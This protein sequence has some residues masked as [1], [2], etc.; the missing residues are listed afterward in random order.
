ME[1]PASLLCGCVRGGL[2]EGSPGFWV[3]TWHHFQ[4]LHPLP[5][6]NWRPSSCFPGVSQSGWVCICLKTVWALSVN[7]PENP[8][9]SSA[10]PT[11]TGFYSQ[12][13]W[14]FIFPALEP[15][16]VRSGLGLGS[17]APKVSLLIFIHHTSM[18]DHPCQF[19]HC[20]HCCCCLSSPHYV[21]MSPPFPPVWMNGLLYIL[22]CQTSI[23]LDFF[24]VLGIICFEV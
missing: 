13:L 15:W 1:Q 4:S 18:W 21:S 17:L 22:G 5:V 19:C 10:A 11:P 8:E 14:G 2:K 3:F 16:T 6:C 24:M 20:H 9:A 23:Y 7:F 12:K